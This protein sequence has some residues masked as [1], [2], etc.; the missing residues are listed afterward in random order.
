VK[1]IGDFFR[2]FRAHDRSRI[3]AH[4]IGLYPRILDDARPLGGFALQ[5]CRK[6]GGAAAD[7]V[8][9]LARHLLAH[10]GHAQRAQYRGVELGDDELLP[11]QL[12]QLAAEYARD[13]I[14]AAA[15]NGR[16]RRSY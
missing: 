10:A 13:R 1:L 11:E 7:R 3:L 15:R 9:S 5:V 16:N 8:E 2:P 14:G 4:L 6:F 12:T